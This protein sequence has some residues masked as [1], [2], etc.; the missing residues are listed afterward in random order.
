MVEQASAMLRARMGV[1]PRV[2]LVL[3]SGLG[4]LCEEIEDAVRVPM[5][6]VPGLV[7]PTVA[8]HAGALIAGRLAGTDCIALQ[9]RL[10]LYEGHDAALVALPVRLMAGLGG[11]TLLVTNAAGGIDR[12]F[13]AG[14]LMLIDDHINLMWRNPLIGAV[15]EGDARFPDLSDAYDPRLRRVA[16]RVALRLGLPLRCGV[17]GAVLG[18]SYE[19]PAE[20]RMLARLGGH[21]VGMSTVPEVLTARALGVRVLG[22]SL[23]TNPAAG[24]TAER[25]RHE[26]V[27]AAGER[28]RSAFASLVRGLLR[29]PELRATSPRQPPRTTTGTHA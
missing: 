29:E 1:R 16:E 21:A 20:I 4:A 23:I 24:L 15:V 22:I 5:D 6:A 9:G 7:A 25:L 17:Y 18:P 11:H 13:S 26:D 19:T 28:A 3:G 2:M 8:G 12:R 27:L 10:H 14:D